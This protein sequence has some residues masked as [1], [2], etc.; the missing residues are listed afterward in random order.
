[1]ARLESIDLDELYEALTEATDE[2]QLQR[3]MVAILY[4]QGP[5]VPMIADWFD[6]RAGT[7]YRWF[8]RLEAEPI[9]QAIQDRPRLGRP[10]KLTDDQRRILEETLEAPPSE[11]GYDVSAWTP[12]ITREFIDEEFGIEYTVRH[13]RR[14]MIDS[15]VS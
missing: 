2:T 13:V 9:N 1:M 5:S 3:L 6:I 7:I 8:N 11:R 14:L 15:D 4:K 10:S 12:E